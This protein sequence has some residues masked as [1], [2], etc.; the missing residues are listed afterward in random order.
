MSLE[1]VVFVFCCISALHN[2]SRLRR[3]YY[4]RVRSRLDYFITQFGRPRINSLNELHCV[5][6][7]TP[8]YNGVVIKILGKH[9]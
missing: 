3:L 6:E 8:Q 7:K 5:H 9:Q 1:I 2:Y 4:F